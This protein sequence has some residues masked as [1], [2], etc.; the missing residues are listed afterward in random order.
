MRLNWL[1]KHKGGKLLGRST[2]LSS[3][4]VHQELINTW[5][6]HLYHGIQH[7]KALDSNTNACSKMDEGQESG[8]QTPTN[9]HP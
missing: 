4:A 1:N 7:T 9:S 8:S 3:M 6:G 5:Q 2:Y